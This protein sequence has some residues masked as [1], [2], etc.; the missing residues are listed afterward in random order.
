[1]I[2]RR[3][4]FIPMAD[5]VTLQSHIYEPETINE[6]LP[7]LL[8][9][10]PYGCEIASTVTY[11]HPS[12]YA[13]QGFIVVIQAVRGC[14]RSGGQFYPFQAAEVSDAQTTIAWCRQLPQSNGRVGMYGFSYQGV[15]QFMA[16]GTAGLM[17]LAPAMATLNFTEGWN[18]WGG[19]LALDFV[20]PWAVQLAQDQA[21]FHQQEPQATMLG[22]SRLRMADWLDYT[23]LNELPLLAD[24]DFGQDWLQP[25]AQAR[26]AQQQIP[27]QELPALHIAGWTDPF[28]VATLAAYETYRQHSTQPQHL[29]IGPWQH[30][31]WSQKVGEMDCGE[32]ARSRMI[33]TY[34]VRWFKLWLTEQPQDLGAPVQIFELGQNRWHQ[35]DQWPLPTHTKTLCL[36]SNGFASGPDSEGELVET[37]PDSGGWDTYVY[38]P[39][40]AT[41]AT[42][43]GPVD[44]RPV[45]QRR[46][47]L[48]YTSAPF[49]ETHT[50]C[51]SPT[52]SLSVSTTAP[53]CDWVIRLSKIEPSGRILLLTAG[54]YRCNH[55]PDQR[56]H[57]HI[58]LRPTCWTLFP[59]DRLQLCLSS[60][61]YP[62]IDRNPNTGQ[63][64]ATAQWSD[65]QTTTQTLWHGSSCLELPFLNKDTTH[66]V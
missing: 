14:D 18:L 2:N 41:P 65:F 34:Q 46:D 43:Y 38:D 1:M 11:A 29:I 39:R 15:T 61:A 30:L 22:K 63:W 5:G 32:S 59:R 44:Q 12:W 35:A 6:P 27:P 28:I 3:E 58:S 51:G 8:M 7:V 33:D 48:L 4:T 45:Q 25:P 17:T 40:I 31:P 64:P 26:Y 37:M 24:C 23:P 60:A 9:R 50:L 66:R 52:V 57:I 36:H 47:L 53:T 16:A 19:A 56:T 10:L 49:S 62:W 13:A 54:V 21:Q 42:A 20:V 55:T